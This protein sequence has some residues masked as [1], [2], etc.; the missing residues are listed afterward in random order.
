MIC[1]CWITTGR[2]G[3][4]ATEQTIEQF[5]SSGKGLVAVHAASY[6][7][8]GL[9]VLG[10]R[11]ARTG[12]F[13]PPWPAYG[14]MVGGQYSAEEP[15][16]GHGKRHIFTV[17]FR[18][19]DHAIA[20]GLPETFLAN[21]ELYH[22]VRMRPEAKILA[23]AFDDP[24]MGGTGKEEPVL[25]T[26]KFGLGRVFHTT[27][28]H[29]AT[30]MAQPGFRQTLRR[31]SEWAA[32]GGVAPEAVTR[33]VAPVRAMLVVGGH[34]HDPS[35]YS[36][37]EHHAGIR[38]NVNPHP[39]AFEGDMRRNYDVLV[40]YD[41]LSGLTEK[42]RANLRDFAEAG[43]GIVVLHHALASNADWPWWYEEVVGGRY[44]LEASTYRHDVPLEVQPAGAHPVLQGIPPMRLIDETYR[45]MW[46]SPRNNVILQT[47]D[48]W[49]DG[50]VAW[51][52]G[53]AKSRVAVIQLGHGREAH[54]YPPFR[55]LV[56]N[57]ILWA[58]GRL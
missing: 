56:R 50:P 41:L 8:A 37:F 28:G 23:T 18:R 40:L 16:T 2:D 43:K 36:V 26:M 22:H 53:Y 3:A 30:A 7:F 20:H 52:S 12:F 21:D 15:K 33:K 47:K 55:Q 39:K 45:G 51:I 38:V 48:P 58:G 1:W 5:V 46:F 44:I 29:D 42:K 25:W 32:T 31:G 19:R 11:H 27:L 13:E 34:D 24:E 57:A 54:E 35:L 17:T 14:E 10:D 4:P 49:S 6:A 9:E